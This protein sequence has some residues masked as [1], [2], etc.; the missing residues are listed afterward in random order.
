MKEGK[1]KLIYV[2]N[3]KLEAQI[4]SSTRHGVTNH[5]SHC[6]RLS[7]NYYCKISPTSPRMNFKVKW[8]QLAANMLAEQSKWPRHQHILEQHL[9]V[10]LN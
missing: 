6:S 10:S 9:Q 7:V 8:L 1:R 5:F 4:C 2:Q 3:E